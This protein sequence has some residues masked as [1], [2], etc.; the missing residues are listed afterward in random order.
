VLSECAPAEIDEIKA[1][2]QKAPDAETKA[3]LEQNLAQTEAF[4]A[5]LKTMK[6]PLPTR[7]VSG[8]VTMKEG[9]RDI[10]LLLLGPAHTD[11]DLSS[12]CQRRRSWRPATP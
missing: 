5:E 7:T 4:L 6:P 1:D 12:T 3:R 9:G 10:Q 11:G 8:D 2:I